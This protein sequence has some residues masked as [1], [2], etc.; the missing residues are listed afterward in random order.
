MKKAGILCAALAI[1]LLFSACG[2]GDVG[3]AESEST[4]SSQTASSGAETSSALSADSVSD[5]LSGLQEYL[6][7]NAGFTGTPEEMQAQIIGAKD[8][9]RYEFGH[10]GKNNVTVELYEYDPD[11]LGDTAQKILSDVKSS[12]KFTLMEQELS[13]EL[14]DSGKYL[15]I[16][17][18]TATDDGNKTYDEQVKTLFRGFKS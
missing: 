5:D 3:G 16:Y 8:G 1:G 14:S 7:A 11:A 10:D 18:N 12:G 9:V 15:M 2:V 6:V 4:S 13:A 17:K